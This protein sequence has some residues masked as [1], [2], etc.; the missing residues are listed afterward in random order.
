MEDKNPLPA[1]AQMSRAGGHEVDLGRRALGTWWR[2]CGTRRTQCQIVT[3][4]LV[5]KRAMIGPYL[6]E[7]IQPAPG[8]R[9]QIFGDSI[10]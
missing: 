8:Q 4:G 10:T 5:A 9:C 7:I 1:A 2:P 3:R 6:Q